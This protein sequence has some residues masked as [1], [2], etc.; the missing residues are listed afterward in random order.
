[1]LRHRPHSRA[2][3]VLLHP[4]LGWFALAALYLAGCVLNFLLAISTSQ[5]W[6]LVLAVTLGVV[7]VLSG[8][9]GTRSLRR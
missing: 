2:R 9:A 4:A 7:A 8:Y 1:M 6:P 3:N 5:I